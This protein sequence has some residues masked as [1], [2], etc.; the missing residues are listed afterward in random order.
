MNPW[1]KTTGFT[2]IEL[3]IVVAIVAI[4]AAVAYPSYQ[5][6]VRRGARAE[7][8][9]AMLSMSQL[10]E[11]NFTNCGTY[12][13]ITSGD[14]SGS[15]TLSAWK[16]AN[17]SGSTF[18]AR[19]YDITVSVTP[20]GCNSPA[21]CGPATSCSGFAITAAPVSPFSDPKCGN[22]TLDGAGNK[23]SNGTLSVA[24]CWR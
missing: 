4:L 16:N 5:D 12:V 21:S 20:T 24:D 18:S 19:K 1:S 23:G 13:G 11:R 10:Q 3:M 2:L 7:A 8:R 15:A 17:W 6:F 14:L 9:A 22:L